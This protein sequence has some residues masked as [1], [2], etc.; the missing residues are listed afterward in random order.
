MGELL[1]SAAIIGLAVLGG[2]YA[3]GLIL[4]AIIGPPA[5]TCDCGCGNPMP[6]DICSSECDQRCQDNDHYEGREWEC[7]Y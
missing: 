3:I 4:A 1:I 6:M 2:V 7:H 5:G